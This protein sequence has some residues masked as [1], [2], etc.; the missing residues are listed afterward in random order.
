MVVVVAAFSLK[1]AHLKRRILKNGP[2]FKVRALDVRGPPR[3][4][5]G[6][7]AAVSS[8]PAW[9]L[10][11]WCRGLVVRCLR[12]A[13]C[14][15]GVFLVLVRG[16]VVRVFGGRCAGLRFGWV[17]VGGVVRLVSL[18]SG[19]LL[20]GGAERACVLALERRGVRS[21]S[22]F[23]GRDVSR[24]GVCVPGG[25]GVCLSWA[26]FSFVPSSVVRSFF[27][28]FLSGARGRCAPS[29]APVAV[30]PAVAAS[31]VVS[32]VV[33]PA[34]GGCCP[35]SVRPSSWSGSVLLLS[36]PAFVG[37]VRGGA[38]PVSLALAS[39]PRWCVRSG[40]LGA[41]CLAGRAGALRA[42]VARAGFAPVLRSL[43]SVGLRSLGLSPSLGGR[44]LFSA[45]SRFWVGGV[46]P[47]V[48]SWA[49]AAFVRWELFGVRS[50]LARLVSSLRW[51][52]RRGGVCP[53]AC[54]PLLAGLL[55][56]ACLAV[57]A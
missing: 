19:R 47:P 55:A 29:C 20:S 41:L 44:A 4:G 15:L 40:L 34:G 17:R 21:L 45:C 33:P 14:W 24:F 3:V 1:E 49:G 42:G 9:L 18:R 51:L 52:V 28:P 53:P 7:S 25:R 56:W 43:L 2:K 31:S 57:G 32:A 23:V 39:F 5:L 8:V 16:C 11:A 22:W 27:A 50:A 38:C 30:L 26:V 46:V 36:S 10:L 48:P 6:V 12:G 13:F 54:R 37:A 35:A